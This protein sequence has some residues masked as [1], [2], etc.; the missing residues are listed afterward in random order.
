M[1]FGRIEKGKVP[2]W[3]ETRLAEES[4]V[5]H[6]PKSYKDRLLVLTVRNV[7][8]V[9]LNYCTNIGCHHGGSVIGDSLAN[10]DMCPDDMEW[11][12]VSSGDA[13]Q[14]K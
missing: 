4:H 11:L 13:C 1:L 10:S 12:C 9:Q 14:Q 3:I 2:S 8:W 6:S 5:K 7:L